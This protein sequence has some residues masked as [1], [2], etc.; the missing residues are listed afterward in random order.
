[1][2]EGSDVICSMV[3]YLTKKS[4]PGQRRKIDYGDV[5]VDEV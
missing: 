4:D 5:L 3:M 2:T 1:M